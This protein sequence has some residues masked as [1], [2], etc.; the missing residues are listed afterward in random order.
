MSPFGAEA[1]TLPYWPPSV[2]SFRTVQEA[3]GV[4]AR[5]AQAETARGGPEPEDDAATA[6]PTASSGT[7]TAAMIAAP[8]SV[9]RDTR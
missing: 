3:M 4:P 8:R 6:T 1:V 5:P 2:G 9:G 7:L